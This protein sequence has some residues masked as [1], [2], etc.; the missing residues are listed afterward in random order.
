MLTQG[1][2]DRPLIEFEADS[3]RLPLEP[4]T[5][6]AHPRI[7]RVWLVVEDTALTFLR[8]CRLQADIVFGI[9]PVDAD[10]GGELLRR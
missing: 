9:R 4:R 5:Q 7:D 1:R 2:D 6:G 10:E 3:N 8:A